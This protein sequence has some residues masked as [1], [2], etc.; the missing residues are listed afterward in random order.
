VNNS[1]SCWLLLYE[2]VYITMCGPQNVK[3]VLYSVHNQSSTDP[4]YCE[5]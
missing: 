5:I 2:Y 4:L 3:F 1:A